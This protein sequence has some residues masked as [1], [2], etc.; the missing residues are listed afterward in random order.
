MNHR[1]Y[2][3]LSWGL[4]CITLNYVYVETPKGKSLTSM[5]DSAGRTVMIMMVRRQFPLWDT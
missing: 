4:S 1:E 3:G 5:T 2:D